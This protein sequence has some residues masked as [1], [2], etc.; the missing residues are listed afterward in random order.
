LGVETLALQPDGRILIG[1]R[2]EDFGN[3]TRN[4]LA[5]LEPNGS[6]DT[7]F[8]PAPD[9]I[10]F[11]IGL[12]AN[13]HI[14]VG[15]GFTSIN[16]LPRPRIARLNPDG[17]VDTRF[18]PGAGPNGVVFAVALQP[19]GRVLLGGAFT[20][21][22]GTP[23][24][25]LARLLSD[26]SLDPTFDPGSGPN[27]IVYALALQPDG[28][29]LAAGSF[30]NFAGN[31]RHYVVRLHPDGTQ[32]TS[33]QPDV[34]LTFGGVTAVRVAP[35]GKILIG[36]DFQTIDGARRVGIARLQAD[37]RLDTTFGGG[38]E[39]AY[40][41]ASVIVKG[42][43]LQA[44]GNVLFGGRFDSVNGVKLNYLARLTGDIGG[45]VEFANAGQQFDES[46]GIISIP[47]R[48]IGS[49]AGI[50]SVDVA[51]TGGNATPEK[52]FVLSTQT[53]A[54]A[55]GETSQFLW[56]H[57]PP[58][59]AGEEDEQIVLSLGNPL[60]GILLGP[61]SSATITLR[62]TVIPAAP[63]FTAIEIVDVDHLR[64]TLNAATGS[65]CILEASPNLAPW[66]AIQTNLAT[67]GTCRF[68]VP[69]WSGS[70]H[71]FFRSRVQ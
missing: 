56:V 43:A 23:R 51:V 60:S 45:Q 54:F 11:G 40:S 21:I 69:G 44:D 37:G 16:G 2:F 3:P 49:T 31:Q 42:I 22:G 27:D 10:V 64:L 53:V 29:L 7:T 46:A 17:S 65:T 19:D 68:T 70:N 66:T 14:L 24:N 1:G 25:R 48:R 39:P 61:T 30:T 58:D 38:T 41:T 71:R 52:D 15:G 9:L 5:R 63:D 50:A 13:G 62:D 47:L 55:P 8:L 18:D 35:D 67:D 36:G 57:I 59:A 12:Q 6:L 20:A 28:N 34:T 32:D 4:Y 33:F 26:G